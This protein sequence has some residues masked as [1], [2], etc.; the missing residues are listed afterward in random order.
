MGEKNCPIPELPEVVLIDKTNY[1]DYPGPMGD[2]NLVWGLLYNTITDRYVDED[3][4][5]L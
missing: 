3:G 5:E 1:K 4:E 2:G